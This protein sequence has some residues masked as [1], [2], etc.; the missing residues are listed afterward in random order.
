MTRT[1]E[2]SKHL[3][4]CG[5]FTPHCN[6][7][8]WEPSSSLDSNNSIQVGRAG[9]PS[10]FWSLLTRVFHQFEYTMVQAQPGCSHVRANDPKSLHFTVQT[11]RQSPIPTGS[12]LNFSSFSFHLNY[13]I[14]RTQTDLKVKVSTYFCLGKNLFRCQ[15]FKDISSQTPLN[16]SIYNQYLSSKSLN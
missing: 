7:W 13:R 15:V 2:L 8:C 11:H 10:P 12:H 6:S 3:S 16:G 4:N 1:G 5:A 9:F 14:T